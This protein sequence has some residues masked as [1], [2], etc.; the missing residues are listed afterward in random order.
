MTVRTADPLFDPVQAAKG[1]RKAR[2]L[3]NEQQ[4]LKNV[5]RATAAS[6]RQGSSNIKTPSANKSTPAVPSGLAALEATSGAPPGRKAAL[7]SQLQRTRSATASLGRF[8]KTLSADDEKLARKAG[9]K[10]R[11]FE[12]N[13]ELAAGT[14]RDHNM[15]LLKTLGRDDK[16]AALRR[17]DKGSKGQGDAELVNSRKAI[18]HASRGQGAA[19]LTGAKAGKGGRGRK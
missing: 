8:D 18:R 12:S 11:K 10:K 15:K 1:E 7:E 9:N 5:Q 14:E 19:A 3:K 16:Q 4:H 2:K 13:S 17:H 6:L